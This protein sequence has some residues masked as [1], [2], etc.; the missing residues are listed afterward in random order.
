MIAAQAHTVVWHD[1]ECGSY[2][3]DLPLWR[4]LARA[5]PQGTVLDVGAGSGRVALELARSGRRVIALDRDAQ[6]LAALHERAAGLSLTTVCADARDFQ[7]AHEQPIA[8]CLAAMQ[9]V[10]L[11][12]DREQRLAFLR[13]VRAQLRPGGLLACA[14]VVDIEP[15]DHSTDDALPPPEEV[16]IAGR[17]Y[18]SQ[19]VRLAS[20]AR[21]IAIERARSIDGRDVERDLIELQRIGVGQLEREGA[22]AGLTPARARWIAATA[23]YC[24]SA[25]V[26]LRA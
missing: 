1:L 23:E 12:G 10:Q 7:L 22:A 17:C 3:A 4:E 20:D 15:F 5:H 19:P 25:V 6:L 21:T 11:L 16:E 14:L 2:R 8:L 18:S 13:C 9:T 26:M 24:G